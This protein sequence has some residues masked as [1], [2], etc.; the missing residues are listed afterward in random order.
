M[1]PIV[2]VFLLGLSYLLLSEKRVGKMVRKEDI[3]KIKSY[4]TKVYKLAFTK[5]TLVGIRGALP[6]ENGKLIANGN[7]LNE[8][9]DSLVIITKDNS[10]FFQGT[11]DP[12][13]YYAINPMNPSGTAQVVPGLYIYTKG[14]HGSTKYGTKF[15][16]FVPYSNL[17]VKRDGNRNL[18][19]DSK[20][21]N[22]IG[23]FG[24]NI[25]AQFNSGEVERNSAG[26]TV[27]K[28]KWGSETWKQFYNLL[29]NEETFQYMVVEAKD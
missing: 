19:W 27:V 10:Y 2:P 21:K 11:V 22:Q 26:C 7:A 24:I 20:D 14:Y 5:P 23:K 1:N 29:K 28:A 9:N 3:E 6:D 15:P 18:I 12:G 4:G 13:R 8:W 16:A 25:H 17:V